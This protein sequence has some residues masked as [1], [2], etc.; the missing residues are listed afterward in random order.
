[1]FFGDHNYDEFFPGISPEA[2]KHGYEL[3]AVP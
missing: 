1:V 2:P 3:A